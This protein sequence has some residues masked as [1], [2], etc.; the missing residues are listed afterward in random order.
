MNDWRSGLTPQEAERL[1]EI[2]EQARLTSIFRIG[3]VNIKF[4]ADDGIEI[5]SDFHNYIYVREDPA[6][7]QKPR[8][9]PTTLSGAAA[10]ASQVSK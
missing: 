8:Q 6:A 9:S 1:A 2:Q 10:A 5:D 7:E 3:H 4:T